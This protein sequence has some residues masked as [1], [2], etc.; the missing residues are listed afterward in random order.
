MIAGIGTADGGYFAL[1]AFGAGFGHAELAAFG[2]GVV[3]YDGAGLVG[4]FSPFV[5]DFG[6]NDIGADGGVVGAVGFG[7]GAAQGAGEH[8]YGAGCAFLFF[9]PFGPRLECGALEALLCKV[10]V[11]EF[12]GFDTDGIYEHGLE[13]HDGAA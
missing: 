8:E 2:A 4:Y 6:I 13:G 10:I 12:A 1:L 9:S 7:D 5:V 3:K 11:H